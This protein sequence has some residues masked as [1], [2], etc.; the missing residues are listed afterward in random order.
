MPANKRRKFS[1][2]KGENTNKFNEMESEGENPP[3]DLPD[4][5]SK[6]KKR[7]R[8][9]KQ[10]VSAAVIKSPKWKK[11]STK[12]KPSSKVMVEVHENEEI[13]T[14]EVEGMDAEFP[15]EVQKGQT[16]ENTSSESSCD[17]DEEVQGQGEP[18]SSWGTNN[19]ATKSRSPMK[20]SLNVESELGEVCDSEADTIPE[21]PPNI[22]SLDID[23]PTEEFGE[24]EAVLF[25]KWE[26]YMK[27]KGLVRTSREV[28]EKERKDSRERSKSSQRPTNTRREETRVDRGECSRG[29]R[30]MTSPSESTIYRPAVEKAREARRQ[31]SSSEEIDTSDSKEMNSSNESIDNLISDFVGRQRLA[32][33]DMERK[34]R[35]DSMQRRQDREGENRRDWGNDRPYEHGGYYGGESLRRE[36]ERA[37]QRNRDADKGKAKIF[38]VP[39]KVDNTDCISTMD[40]DFMILAAH[41]DDVLTK[42]IMLGEYVNFSKLI[43]KDRISLEEDNRLELV[44]KGGNSYWVPVADREGTAI[45][46]IEKWDQAFRVF[47]KIDSKGN[48][49]RGEEL[50]EYSF[51]IHSAAS[52]FS[53]SNVYTYDKLFRMHMAKHPG[54]NWGIILQQA[55]SFCLNDRVSANSQVFNTSNNQYRGGEGRKRKG[56]ICFGFNAGHCEYG[57]S[58]KFE[59]KC[60]ICG[61]YG[62][63]AFNCR[64]AG[65]EKKD[66]AKNYQ[67]GWNGKPKDSQDKNSF[68]KG[69]PRGNRK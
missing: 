48:P 20:R 32:L 22:L 52:I 17:S 64:H 59:H 43:Q 39:G 28:K 11:K 21:E 45:T 25:A 55:W 40:Q 49:L 9:T 8:K 31:S 5:E 56:K 18:S 12:S 65:L 34:Q 33:D 2:K 50:V 54:Q 19:N 51:I 6:Q 69:S 14:M 41:I 61:K 15:E 7:G 67:S 63:G 13:V 1:Q 53:W 24:K 23:E 68:H 36:E 57:F 4:N 44:N 10:G 37:T 66:K 62:H 38:D 27:Q 35:F 58:C 46:S 29:E 16:D 60:G 47:S 3:L 42:K 26:K 30:S